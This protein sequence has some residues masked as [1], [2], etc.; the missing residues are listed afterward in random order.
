MP[1]EMRAPVKR[2]NPLQVGVTQPL[3]LIPVPILPDPEP[4]ET[5]S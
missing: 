2:G 3:A 5:N 1:R 4:Q